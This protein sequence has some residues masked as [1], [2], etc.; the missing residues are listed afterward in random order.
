M[1]ERQGVSPNKY[2]L[3]DGCL[4]HIITLVPSVNSIRYLLDR[5]ASLTVP[6]M[7]RLDGGR[8]PIDINVYTCIISRKGNFGN[9]D[10]NR[11]KRLKF[12][13]EHNLRT[14]VP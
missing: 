13:E 3:H 4:K 1:I 9:M 6:S 7:K 2:V 8:H 12:L 5:G 10:E 11:L 14:I